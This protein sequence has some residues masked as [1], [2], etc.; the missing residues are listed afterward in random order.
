MKSKMTKYRNNMKPEF[1]RSSK[2]YQDDCFIFWKCSGGNVNNLHNLLQNLHPK[3]E[4]IN[5]YNLQEP[6]FLD[7]LIKNQNG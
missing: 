7:T 1:I 6:P 2:R 5:E 3:I 4:F